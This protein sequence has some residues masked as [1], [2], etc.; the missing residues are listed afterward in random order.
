MKAQM[1]GEDFLIGFLFFFLL[2]TTI[3]LF[4]NSGGGSG[5]DFFNT[6][7]YQEDRFEM[8][9]VYLKDYNSDTGAFNPIIEISKNFENA[10]SVLESKEINVSF[11]FRRTGLPAGDYDQGI[12][13]MPVKYSIYWTNFTLNE[14]IFNSSKE[15]TINS[16]KYDETTI[17]E[18]MLG[19]ATIY[20][21]CES[22]IG[23]KVELM[24]D[25]FIETK[26]D[27]NEHFVPVDFCLFKKTD[28]EL[29]N[30][31]LSNDVFSFTVLNN[32]EFIDFSANIQALNS[33][34]EWENINMTGFKVFD[35]SNN[36]WEDVEVAGN[37]FSVDE[38]S[39][40]SISFD[41]NDFY[42]GE[43]IA[44]NKLLKCSDF[45]AFKVIIDS[46]GIM[47]YDLSNNEVL[48]EAGC[49]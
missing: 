20:P 2:A 47:E 39:E 19:S 15:W 16:Y 22:F 26:L 11:A 36:Q 3:L 1:V 27:N 18:T 5:I 43:N 33:S 29:S 46:V 21:D 6:S 41:L 12:I 35:S 13:S 48:Q 4:I 28:L 17:D 44:E 24:S 42:S 30:P 7:I 8:D 32:Y 14:G 38:H 9:Y 10:A 34:N 25:L 31:E 49:Q 23:V 37:F 40:I 45:S